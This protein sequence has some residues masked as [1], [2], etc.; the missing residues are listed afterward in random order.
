MANLMT[1]LEERCVKALRLS[2]SAGTL[3]LTEI[4]NNIE[5]ARAELIRA[6]VSEEKVQEEDS[7]VQQAIIDYVLMEMNTEDQYDRYLNAFQYQMDNLRKSF[8]KE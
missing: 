2:T 1:N 5:A 3:L 8:P 7:L 6:G 4:Q